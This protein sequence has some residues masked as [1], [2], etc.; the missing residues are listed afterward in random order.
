[1][2]NAQLTLGSG[3]N[4]TMNVTTDQ[5]VK[6][7]RS[8]SSIKSRESTSKHTETNGGHAKAGIGGT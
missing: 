5:S 2:Y 6:F 7:T 8:D 3:L 4:F 1:M